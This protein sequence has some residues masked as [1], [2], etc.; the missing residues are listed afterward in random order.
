[1][2]AMELDNA[3]DRV[4]NLDGTNPNDSMRV[5]KNKR[6]G[7]NHQI[8][9]RTRDLTPEILNKV[10][11]R[12]HWN[13]PE[14]KTRQQ[15]AAWAMVQEREATVQR[16]R[17]L[18]TIGNTIF[19]RRS[20]RSPQDIKLEEHYEFIEAIRQGR[21]DLMD[22]GQAANRPGFTYAKEGNARD[23]AYGVPVQFQEVINRAWDNAAVMNPAIRSRAWFT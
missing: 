8:R 13:E 1:M 18:E 17:F 5:H 7:T 4:L 16:D 22:V 21:V 20:N 3:F 6:H 15:R 9:H 11:E 19:S 10:V 23:P 14:T 12:N 2:A